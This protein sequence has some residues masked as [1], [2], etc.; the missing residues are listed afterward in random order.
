[1]STPYFSIIIPMYNVEKYIKICVD[2]LLAQTFQDFEIIIVDDVSTDNSYEICKKLYGDNE[3]IRLIQ[4][5]KNQ[6]QGSARNQ[7]LK[8]AN[9][10]YIWFVDA[11]DIALPD[12]LKKSYK[13]TQ[14]AKDGV[15]VVHFLGHYRSHQDDDK[16]I[17]FDKLEIAWENR[18][19]GLL[20]SD[21]K[22]R[23]VKHW[24]KNR[25]WANAFKFIYKRKFLIDNEIIYPDAPMAQDQPMALESLCL[26][27]SYLMFKDNSYIYR[28]RAGSIVHSPRIDKF[29]KAMKSFTEIFK[30]VENFSK[31]IPVLEDNRLLKEQC[32][33]QT[34]EAIFRDQI[35]P[36]Y[37]G[38]NISIELDKAIYETMLPHFGENTTF[39]KYL[40][41]GFNNNWRQ[42]NILAQ[43]NY[44]LRQ[45]E[46]LIQQQNK[47]IEQLT[48]L[49]NQCDR[50]IKE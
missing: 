46:D 44:L 20:G 47:L 35:R 29:E 7:G 33:M 49:L 15:D 37:N 1:M 14:A 26:A 38:S 30:R 8:I 9:G 4:Q 43:Q 31:K 45:R 22:E 28:H 16:P 19:A 40:F 36:L 18:Q 21:I 2:S 42:K 41:H 5:E 50:Q 48:R 3:K 12:V 39:V 23:I 34:F 11:D 25:I 17:Q 32:L 6:G 13:A 27:K 10:K 24:I